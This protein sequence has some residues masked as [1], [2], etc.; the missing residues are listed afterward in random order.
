MQGQDTTPSPAPSKSTRSGAPRGLDTT[1]S[2]IAAQRAEANAAS[3]SQAEKSQD[4]VM[5]DLSSI[6]FQ[7]SFKEAAKQLKIDLG[8]KSDQIPI[9]KLNT[10]LKLMATGAMKE[11]E[12]CTDLLEASITTTAEANK[13]IATSLNTVAVWNEKERVRLV[14]AIALEKGNITHFSISEKLFLAAEAAYN[15]ANKIIFNP[16]YLKC[17]PGGS[18]DN[19]SDE[20]QQEMLLLI[21]SPSD[22]EEKFAKQVDKR[23]LVNKCKL[24]TTRLKPGK[25][26]QLCVFN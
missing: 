11:V 13:S 9:S 26:Y 19:T 20:Y 12:E 18:T 22:T 6:D 15:T 14:D 17:F 8:S 5:G 10:L 7:R 24:E 4:A 1:A 16:N 3:A 25:S 21:D 2:G 23:I